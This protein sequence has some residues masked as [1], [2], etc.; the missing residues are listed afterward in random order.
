[1]F[2]VPGTSVTSLANLHRKYGDEPKLVWLPG[3][4]D[5]CAVVPS[6][7][8]RK[9]KYVTAKWCYG[10]GLFKEKQISVSQTRLVAPDG[11]RIPEDVQ[12]IEESLLF[13]PSPLRKKKKKKKGKRKKGD[14]SSSEEEEE[15]EED[16]PMSQEFDLPADSL[17][18]SL[19]SPVERPPRVSLDCVELE[20]EWKEDDDALLATVNGPYPAKTWSIK[21]ALGNVHTERSDTH[22]N[23]SRIEYFFLMCP[24]KA[25]TRFQDCTN[26]L[27][28]DARLAI[29]NFEEMIRFF[30]IVVLAT[31]FEFTT[32]ASLWS[33]VRF[34]RFHASP[35]FGM[36]GMPRN[37]FDEIWRYMRFSHQPPER[38]PSMSHE[39]HRWTLV[40]DFVWLFNEH[41]VEQF[42]PSDKI[43][44][45]ESI[46][47]WYGLGGDWI[48]IGL[49]MYVAMDRKPE[50]GCEIQN[51]CCAKS[52]VMLR[53]RLRKTKS[54]DSV[55]LNP[56]TNHG[57]GVLRD[58][59]LPWAHS[60]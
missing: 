33:T 16:V 35:G 5:T 49:P 55:D 28:V 46:S 29:V 42:V 34:S 37:R 47:R 52:G 17:F 56:D 38:P 2:F 50:N 26:P 1:L 53:L 27:L 36:T 44:V 60:D 30:G 25:L 22:K 15:E 48:N 59:V 19:P 51:S 12:L 24:P 3:R 8:G 54:K 6:A 57:T 20:V 14:A 11:C 21:D 10:G 43:C 4:V 40:A 13:R 18:T 32:R 7:T 58:L 9:Q 31:R 23:L 41:R 39:E 45:D